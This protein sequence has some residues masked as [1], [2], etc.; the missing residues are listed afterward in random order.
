[1]SPIDDYPNSDNYKEARP[2]SGIFPGRSWQPPYPGPIDVFPFQDGLFGTA[3]SGCCLGG[4]LS[5]AP[6]LTILAC[7]GS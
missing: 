7:A 1:M 4:S 3:F 6:M 5:L 2:P